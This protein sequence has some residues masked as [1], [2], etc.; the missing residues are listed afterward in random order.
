MAFPDHIPNFVSAFHEP[1]SLLQDI[2]QVLIVKLASCHTVDI[3]TFLR[4]NLLGFRQH[5]VCR[6]IGFGQTLQMCPSDIEPG[7]KPYVEHSIQMLC[8]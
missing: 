7:P 6:C 4:S 5:L 8:I 1:V 2:L 3:M